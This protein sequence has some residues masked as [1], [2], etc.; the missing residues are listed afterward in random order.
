MGIWRTLL[1]DDRDQN[2]SG[3]CEVPQMSDLKSHSW[4]ASRPSRRTVL[5]GLAAS[6]VGVLTGCGSRGGS[7]GNAQELRVFVYAGGHDKTMRE[8]FVPSFESQT[9]ATVTLYSGWWD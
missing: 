2:L 9:G 4:S 1:A 8:V 6:A 3:H 5:Q 7:G